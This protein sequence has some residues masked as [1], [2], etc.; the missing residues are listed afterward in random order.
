MHCLTAF[1]K[2]TGTIS[3]LTSLGVQQRR[4]DLD[5]EPSL[6]SMGKKVLSGEDN[7]PATGI[8]AETFNTLPIV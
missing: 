2:L 1:N 4:H 8:A 3:V 7:V 6:E 5:N